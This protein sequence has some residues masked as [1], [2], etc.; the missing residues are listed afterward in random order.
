MNPTDPHARP[1]RSRPSSLSYWRSQHFTLCKK[2]RVSHAVRWPVPL[3]TSDTMIYLPS[4]QSRDV[5]VRLGDSEVGLYSSPIHM[6]FHLLMSDLLYED[7]R[8][9]SPDIKQRAL[10]LLQQGWEM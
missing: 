4:S 5:R 2:R 10:E 8:Y 6:I 3:P 7:Y 1:Q 9:T